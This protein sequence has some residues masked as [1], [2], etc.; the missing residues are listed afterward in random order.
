M[1]GDLW[2][3]LR[4][5]K[6]IPFGTTE[7]PDAPHGSVLIAKATVAGF[8]SDHN[9]VVN[10]F[11]ANND[12]STISLAKWQTHGCAVHSKI[13]T[14]AQLFVDPANNNYHLKAPKGSAYEL[15]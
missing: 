14:P 3:N 6:A 9:I 13:A 1:N 15:P 7:R 5:W 12:S 8:H 4:R 11:S 2:C 10:V